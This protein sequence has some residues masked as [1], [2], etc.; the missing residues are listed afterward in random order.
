MLPVLALLGLRARDVMGFTF[1][2]FLAL[3]PVVLILV[4][5]LGATL[6]YPL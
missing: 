6:A 4:T 1:L 5:V 3:L 2:G